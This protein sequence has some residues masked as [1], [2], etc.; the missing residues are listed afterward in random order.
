MP[1][2]C[3][4]SVSRSTLVLRHRRAEARS[5]RRPIS[6]RL[7]AACDQRVCVDLGEL[8]DVAVAAILEHELEAAAWCRGRESAAA[9]SANDERALDAGELR[10]RVARRIAVCDCR[11]PS[12]APP[13]ASAVPMTVATFE[14][15]VAVSQSRP[16]KRRHVLDAGR[17]RQD[18][19]DLLGDALRCA[20]ARR[21][22]AAARRRRTRPDL[23]RAGSR[24][25][26]SGTDRRRR[27]RRR[28]SATSASTLRRI[29]DPARRRGTAS[30]R[31]IEARG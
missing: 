4:L 22:R 14:L 23:R 28:P 5:A 11:S 3:T 24:R 18:L 17:R 6:G 25:A 27:G 29:E 16:P 7:L 21:R 26:G 10:L 19:L 8:R 1:S 30:V 2:V 9:R 13:T 20:R 31:P 12:C 15:L